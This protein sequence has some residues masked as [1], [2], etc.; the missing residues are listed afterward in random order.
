MA[1]PRSVIDPGSQGVSDAVNATALVVDAHAAVDTHAVDAELVAVPASV[2]EP[3]PIDL[4]ERH[5]V[6][7]YAS[8][9][10]ALVRLAELVAPEDGLAEDLVQEAFVKL[11]TKRR[12]VQDLDK[13]PAY[14]RSTVINL[15][16]GRGRRLAVAIRNRPAPSPDSSSAEEGAI[17]GEEHRQVIEALRQLPARQRECLVL[18]HYQGMT[19]SEI[20]AALGISVGSVRTH[21]SR[22][23]TA[24]ERLLGDAP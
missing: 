23:S 9:H 1:E 16:R 13:A 10:A 12:R 6:E 21:T 7:L 3:R 4:T 2:D 5:I 14:L 24:M 8:Q 18:R 22:A 19:E 15:A 11:F 17:E 20:A